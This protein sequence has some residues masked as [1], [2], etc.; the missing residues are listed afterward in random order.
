MTSDR[1]SSDILLCLCGSHVKGWGR[2]AVVATS[3]WFYER[4]EILLLRL[5]FVSELSENNEIRYVSVHSNNTVTY[6]E[7]I[8]RESNQHMVEGRLSTNPITKQMKSLFAGSLEMGLTAISSTDRAASPTNWFRVNPVIYTC[9]FWGVSALLLRTQNVFELERKF[10]AHLVQLPCN[11]QGHLQ[12][13]QVAWCTCPT[14]PWMS[15]GN[16]FRCLTTFTVKYFLISSLNLPS[17]SLKPF[18]LALSQQTLL[19]YLSSSFL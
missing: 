16:Q 17:F 7:S 6:P 4:K 5:P 1:Q 12:L 10:T 8:S 9:C 13:D 3:I 11:E 14:L 19:K 2:V 18:P 15:L